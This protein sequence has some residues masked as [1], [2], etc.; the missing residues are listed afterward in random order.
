MEYLIDPTLDLPIK[1]GD[2]AYNW[3]ASHMTTLLPQALAELRGKTEDIPCIIG[4]EEI[5]T[6]KTRD[7]LCVSTEC[8]DNPFTPV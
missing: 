8:T 7:Q 6:G 5:R 1:F 3:P 2:Q 4:G